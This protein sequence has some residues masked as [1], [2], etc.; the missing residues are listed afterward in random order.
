MSLHRMVDFCIKMVH[1]KA[2]LLHGF[3]KKLMVKTHLYAEKFFATNSQLTKFQK[4]STYLGRA[5]R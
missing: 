5:L 2:T 3:L 4:L 1:E